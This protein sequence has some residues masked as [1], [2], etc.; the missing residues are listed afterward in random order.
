MKP[1]RVSG[2]IPM[3]RRTQRF[4][5]EVAAR[6]SDHALEIVLSDLGSKHRLRR[7]Q[8]RVAKVEELTPDQVTDPVTRHRLGTA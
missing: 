7:R 1:F 4:A 6:D 2:T 3:G 5:K 8:V